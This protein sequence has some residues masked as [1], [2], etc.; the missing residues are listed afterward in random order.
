MNNRIYSLIVRNAKEKQTN[1]RV[2]YAHSRGEA[3]RMINTMQW[4]L[5]FS[6]YQM[7][8]AELCGEEGNREFFWIVEKGRKI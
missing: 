2:E 3:V 5:A 1:I 6:T 8:G 4:A 7:M